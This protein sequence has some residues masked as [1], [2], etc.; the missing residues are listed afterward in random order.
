MGLYHR[1]Y[2]LLESMVEDVQVLRKAVDDISD[3]SLNL[4]ESGRRTFR[5]RHDTPSASYRLTKTVLVYLD[6]DPEQ[7]SLSIANKYRFC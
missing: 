2:F 6:F 7:L 1:E 4:S 3:L 5:K